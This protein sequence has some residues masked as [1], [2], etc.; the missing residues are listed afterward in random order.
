MAF[1]AW[2]Q[3]PVRDEYRALAATYRYGPTVFFFPPWPEI[4]HSSGIRPE[5]FEETLVLVPI[6]KAVYLDLGY[7]LVDVPQG[8]VRERAGLIASHVSGVL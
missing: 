8:S 4:Y 2:R 6:L 3:T 1:A 7:Q 5:S